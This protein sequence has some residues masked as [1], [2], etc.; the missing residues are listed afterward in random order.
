M[1]PRAVGLGLV[2]ALAG[3][4]SACRI[5][6]P[7][8]PDALREA[9][10]Q[11]IRDDDPDAAFELLSHE[12][13]QRVGREA[14]RANWRA[15][16]A[17]LEATAREIDQLDAATAEPVWYGTTS[18]PSGRVVRWE[19]IDGH[20]RAVDGLPERAD[21]SSPQRAISELV[22]ALRRSG[23]TPLAAIATEELNARIDRRWLDTADAIERALADPRALEVADDGTHAVLTYGAGRYLVLQQIDGQWRVDELE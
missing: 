14:F 4:T 20:Y 12:A 18:H 19:S 6:G 16:R 9:Y 23:S 3:S 1:S 22:A 11:A 13:Q 8:T 5:R 21:L 17:E 7:Q 15:H 10:A 2:L